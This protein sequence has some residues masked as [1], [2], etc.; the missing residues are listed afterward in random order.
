MKPKRSNDKYW[1]GTRDFDHIQYE[2][3]LEDYISDLEANGANKISSN[4]PVSGSEINPIEKVYE[5]DDA[6]LE[7]EYR[8]FWT[9]RLRTDE[10]IKE[11]E[12]LEKLYRSQKD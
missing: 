12:R 8:H 1:K 10:N 4:L 5:D 6:F 7:I 11:W 9:N 3:D 2:N